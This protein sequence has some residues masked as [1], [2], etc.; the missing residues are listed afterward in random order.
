MARRAFVYCAFSL[1]GATSAAAELRGFVS[2]GG[3]G[4][5]QYQPCN[6]ATLSQQ[7]FPIEDKTPNGSLRAGVGAVRGIM[8][9]RYRPLYVEMRGERG[10]TNTTVYQFQR[11][12]GTVEACAKLPRDIAPNIQLLASGQGPVWR[13]VVTNSA[14]TLE[15]PDK[16]IKLPA[17]AFKTAAT[18]QAAQET[19]SRIYETKLPDGV[20]LRVEVSPQMCTDGKSE[21]AYGARVTVRSGTGVLQG[22]AARF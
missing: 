6:G 17:S 12:I 15:L 3:A 21:T 2:E 13:L 1:F 10:K 5:L 14:A 7:L 9:H 22:C 11:A 4:V 19:V 8:L 16:S 18:D 20:P